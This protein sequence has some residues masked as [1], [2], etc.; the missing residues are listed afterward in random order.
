MRTSVWALQIRALS[1]SHI[2][3]QIFNWTLP[4]P[5]TDHY[6]QPSVEGTDS[7]QLFTWEA[8][9]RA[10]HGVVICFH[11]TIFVVLGTTEQPCALLYLR[12]WFAFIL[13]SL[14]Y[15]KQQ[16]QSSLDLL[17]SCDL[18]SFYYLCR[19]GNNIHQGFHHQNQ[20]VI[21]FHFTIFVVLETTRNSTQNHIKQLWFAFILLSLSYWKQQSTFKAKIGSSCDLLSFYYLCRTGNNTILG[22]WSKKIVVICF[23]FTIFVV[24]ET[25]KVERARLPGWLW[26]AFILLSLSYWKQQRLVELESMCCCDLLSFYYLCRTGN[27]KKNFSPIRGEVV[28]CFHF[29]IFVVLETTDP[30]YITHPHKLWFA[31]ILLSLSYWK[32]PFIWIRKILDSCD[33]LSFYYLCRTGNNSWYR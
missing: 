18:L 25:T 24:L 8:L 19:T 10:L 6:P 17:N 28:I 12:L 11:F 22:L 14:S 33:L 29:T 31:F 2:P 5:S 30:Q 16:K 32:Q 27:N 26:F 7:R 9:N 23:H 21:C 4:E 20:V 1:P 3:L 13:L 15:W